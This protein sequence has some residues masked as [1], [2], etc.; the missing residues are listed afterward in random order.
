MTRLLFLLTCSGLAVLMAPLAAQRPGAPAEAVSSVVQ[1]TVPKVAVL[2]YGSFSMAEGMPGMTAT[3]FAAQMLYL[4]EQGLTPISLQQFIDWKQ[5][6]TTL[7]ERSVLITLDE[8]DASAYAVAFPVLKG[9]G[10]PF[11]I[12]ADGRSF[13]SGNAMLGVDKLL[14]MQQAGAAVGSHS[15]SRPLAHDWVF[16]EQSGPDA[17]QKMAER[18]LGLQAQRITSVFGSCEAFSY[19]RGYANANMVENLAIYGYKIAFGLRPGKVQQDEPS[20]LLNRYMV[21]DM[22]GFARAVNFGD[23]GEDEKVLQQV[24]ATSS[25]LQPV[26]RPA[27]VQSPENAA[28]IFPAF[29]ENLAATAAEQPPLP[30]AVEPLAG[31]T[32][33]QADGKAAPIPPPVVEEPAPMPELKDPVLTPRPVSTKPAAGTLVR[34]EGTG[35]WVSKDFPQPVVPRTETRVAVL[36]YHNFSNTKPVSEMLMR[37]SEFCQQM[38]YIKDAGLTVIT[39]QDFLDWLLG[40][41]CLPARCVLITIDDGWRSVYTDAYPVLKAY[42]YPFTLYLYTTYLSGRGQSMTQ[43]M[44]R[45]MMASGATI[46]SHSTTHLYP[47]QWK[48]YAEDSPEY[49]A[50]LKQEF[51]DSIA[52]LKTMFTHCS[53]YCYPG[54]YHTPPMIACLQEQGIGAAFTVL[55]KKVTTLEDPMQVHRYMVFGTD[56][57]I[58][59]RAVNFD[60]VPGIKP[61]AQGITEARARAKAFFPSAFEDVVQA[62]PKPAEGKVELGPITAPAEQAAPKVHL[63]DIPAPIYTNPY[64]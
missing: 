11:A 35:D 63:E 29:S 55:E 3:T 32:Q 46:G 53:T 2:R 43:D 61:T 54:G 58:F 37:T 26:S 20:F 15:V 40:D 21:N 9:H 4:K 19:P 51:T 22:P 44:V 33:Q 62:A 23:A 7:P 45:E 27:E 49:A 13:Q 47:S 16:A 48:R 5:G 36:G 24:W 50:Q 28:A 42:G 12:F 6:R 38:Q 57:R 17:A 25:G 31:E 10:F 39:M 64:P 59:R 52:E 56:P 60:D 14:E 30:P 34:K 8:A 41:R 1:T 18:E